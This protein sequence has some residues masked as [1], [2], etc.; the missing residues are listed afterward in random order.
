MK[1]FLVI[2]T[3]AILSGCSQHNAE[4]LSYGI[5]DN[6]TITTETNK[7][8]LAGE[9][10]IINSWNL[11]ESTTEIPI[12]IGIE[13][14]IAYVITPPSG[15][16][17]VSIEEVIVFPGEGLTNPISEQSAKT[18]SEFLTIKPKKEQ[19]FSYKLDYPW[20]AK[21]GTWLFQVKQ[22]GVIILQQ[23]FNVHY[24]TLQE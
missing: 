13:F 16:T 2:F 5:V 21:S 24:R 19:Y 3:F 22:D 9:K 1:I 23:S 20:E 8:L 12:K 18:D 11:K 7:A 6:T 4:I 10:R 15:K 17:S 14:G